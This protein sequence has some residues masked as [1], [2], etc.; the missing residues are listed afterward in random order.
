MPQDFSDCSN[1]DV[2]VPD[3]VVTG[4][5]ATVDRGPDGNT[6][7]RAMLGAQ[8]NT[9][10]H[11]FLK[12]VRQLGD[13]KTQ[14]NSVGVANFDFPTNAA[15]DVFAFDMYPEG[16]P[17]GNKYQSAQVDF[18]LTPP[19]VVPPDNPAAAGPSPRIAYVSEVANAIRVEYG[20]MP[21][22]T[23]I[24]L[25][26]ASWGSELPPPIALNQAGA[27]SRDIPFTASQ[28][29][30]YYYFLARAQ[31]DK[32]YIA[33]TVA[34]YITGIPSSPPDGRQL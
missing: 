33:Q 9:T 23:E 14:T 3:T 32:Q 17:L 11:F 29:G 4:G 28:V 31:A 30:G 12:C 6:H 2:R 18:R 21:V 16:A 25:V 15:G 10:Y 19:V 24:I 27:G 22:G 20:D 7:V 8:P 5:M 34:F 13:L 1:A 26:N